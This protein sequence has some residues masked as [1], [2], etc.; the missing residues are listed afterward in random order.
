MFD[1]I[2]KGFGQ[3][4]QKLSL[5]ILRKRSPVPR[6]PFHRGDLW[7]ANHEPL[8][9][10]QIA[11]EHAR[12]GSALDRFLENSARGV[13]IAHFLQ[14]HAQIGVTSGVMRTVGDGDVILCDRFTVTV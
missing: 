7:I 6:K 1:D 12:S 8:A 4:E 10:G 9:I 3:R 14:G 5:I 13:E 11:I 2:G